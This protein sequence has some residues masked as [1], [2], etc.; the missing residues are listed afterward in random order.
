MAGPKSPGHCLSLATQELWRWAM[1]LILTQETPWDFTWGLTKNLI[2]STG[3]RGRKGEHKR[4]LHNYQVSRSLC[5]RIPNNSRQA[6]NIG[7]RMMVASVFKSNTSKCSTFPFK[8]FVGL[9]LKDPGLEGIIPSCHLC[10]CCVVLR[11]SLWTTQKEK[12]FAKLNCAVGQVRE[13]L[14]KLAWHRLL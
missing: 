6:W 10:V 2:C 13:K 3:G 11:S 7:L 9:V 5:Q 1:P 4:F 12:N 8:Y 14:E